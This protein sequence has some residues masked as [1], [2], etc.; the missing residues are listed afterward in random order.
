[1]ATKGASFRYGNTRGA[2]HRGEATKDIKYAWAKD[3]NKG[4]LNRHFTKHAKEF[5]CCTKGEYVAKALRFANTIDRVNFKS[6]VDI[7]D[8]T[9]KYNPKTRVLVEVTKD[10]YII[11]YRH[12]RKTDWYIDKKGVKRW[13]K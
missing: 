4:G 8:T 11:S 5:G 7:N 12:Y 10:G 13:L 9:Y 2:N 3:F 1:M 6:V